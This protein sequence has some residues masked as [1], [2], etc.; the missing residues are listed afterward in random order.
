M[1]RT[2]NTLIYGALIGDY[3]GSNWEFTSRVSQKPESLASIRFDDGAYT[4]DT[5]MTLAVADALL[6]DLDIASMMRRY[7]KLYPCPRGGYGGNFFRWLKDPFAPAYNSCGNGAGMRISPVAYF[8]KSEEDCIALS[9]KVTEISHNHE[10]GMK[11][12][13]ILSLAIYKA[14]HGATKEEL[15]EFITEYYDVDFDLEDLHENYYHVETCQGSLPQAFYCFLSS[16]D[17]EDCLRRVCYIGGDAD[18]IGAMAC[19]LASAYYKKI[20]E[21]LLKKVKA[22]LPKHFIDVLEAVP[23]RNV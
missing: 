22:D 7:Y 11:G 18:T 23:L 15:K 4:D 16:V 19:A 2:K 20:P 5:V 21:N 12:A 10:E 8:A 13:R 9:D 17:F 1:K 14:L 6:N 3:F